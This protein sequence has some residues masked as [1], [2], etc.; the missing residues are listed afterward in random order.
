MLTLAYHMY[1]PEASTKI[2]KLYDFFIYVRRVIIEMKKKIELL[3]FGL[4]VRKQI[5]GTPFPFGQA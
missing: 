1:K 4:G 5:R 2:T 3:S